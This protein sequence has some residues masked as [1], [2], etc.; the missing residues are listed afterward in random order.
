MHW[1]EAAALVVSV[2][3][4]PAAAFAAPRKDSDLDRSGDGCLGVVP[5]K[6][7]VGNVLAAAGSGLGPEFGLAVAVVAAA[8]AA[9]VVAVVAAAVVAAAA[10]GFGSAAG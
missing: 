9:A 6:F 2:S 5:A 8:A 1:L 10:A 7:G 3:S 4:V